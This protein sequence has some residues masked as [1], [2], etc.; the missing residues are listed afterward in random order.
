MLE[1]ALWILIL[2]GL[3]YITVRHLRNRG[4]GGSCCDGEGFDEKDSD[5]AARASRKNLRGR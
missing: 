4:R 3:L 2:G 1:S 5:A